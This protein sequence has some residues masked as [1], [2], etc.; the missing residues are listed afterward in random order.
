ML[1]EMARHQLRQ[2]LLKGFG[3]KFDGRAES[4]WVWHSVISRRLAE[5]QAG[6]MDTLH[7]LATG[8]HRR[9]ASSDGV[10]KDGGWCGTAATH[11]QL[12]VG[13]TQE[14]VRF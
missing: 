4:F 2:D 10:R 8:K 1:D 11:T 12:P 3:T 14:L 7:I 9:C 5:C 13:R 6:A